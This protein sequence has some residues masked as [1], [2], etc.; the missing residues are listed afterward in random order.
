MLTEM[1]Q[2][3]TVWRCNGESAG[4]ATQKLAGSTPG[5]AI[6]GNNLG[7]V[8]HTRASVT[9]QYNLVPVKGRWC[10]PAT[11]KVTVGLASHWPFAR[12]KVKIGKGRLYLITER[13][14]PEL[15]SVLGSQPAGNVSHKPGGRMP[16]L[17]AR[18]AVTPATLKRAAINFAAWWTEA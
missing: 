8:V 6:S 5:L 3:N 13:R 4:L 10:C 16:L 18:S 2:V 17:S 9:K 12:L 14:V 7:Q 11:G 1:K 15:I